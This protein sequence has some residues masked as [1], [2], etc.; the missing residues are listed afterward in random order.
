MS[1]I[2]DRI[3]AYEINSIITETDVSIREMATPEVMALGGL[4][5]LATLAHEPAIA[6]TTFATASYYLSKAFARQQG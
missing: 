3:I 1:E 2:E 4:T 6:A 5:L